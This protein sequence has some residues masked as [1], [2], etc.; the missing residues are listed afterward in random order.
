FKITDFAQRLLD[1]MEQLE[2]TWPERVLALQRNW[3]GRSEGAEVTFRIDETGEDVVVYTTRPD[4]LFGATFFVVAPEHPRARAWAEQGGVA[5]AFDDFFERVK[6]E[7]EIDR[8]STE[9]AKEGLAL[10]VHAVNP[11]NGERLPVYAADYV[12]MDYGTGAIMCVPGH[13]QR[14]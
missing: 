5:D 12:L 9:K 10:G 6:R 4:T 1:D 14:D 3:I 7:S 13:D 2:G 8:L 11:V